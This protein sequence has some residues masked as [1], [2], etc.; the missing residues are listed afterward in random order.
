MVKMNENRWN[1]KKNNLLSLN[2]Q[3]PSALIDLME[4]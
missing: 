1:I 4:I 3:S 2:S